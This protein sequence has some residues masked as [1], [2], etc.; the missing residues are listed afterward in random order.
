MSTQTGLPP[1]WHASVWPEGWDFERD[2]YPDPELQQVGYVLLPRRFH[3]VVHWPE[4]QDG[5]SEYGGSLIVGFEVVG[6]DL[7]VRELYGVDMD[8]EKWL[9]YF[10]KEFPPDR[11]KPF[12]VAEITA[13]LGGDEKR[14]EAATRASTSGKKGVD[15]RKRKRTDATRKEGRKRHRL[16][17]QHLEEVAHV[18]L[19][20]ASQGEPPTMAV[21]EHFGVAHSTAAKWVG[22]ARASGML[23]PVSDSEKD[24]G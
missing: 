14:K 5:R 22:K 16:T 15:L 13:F 1:H 17:P 23:E 3:M 4:L 11:W 6:E 2:Y 7:E 18:Y 8:V 20:A 24:R 12:A 9:G 21:A 10:I 19:D